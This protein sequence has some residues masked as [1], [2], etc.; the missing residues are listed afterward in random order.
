[1]D[2]AVR[3]TIQREVDAGFEDQVGFLQRLVRFPSTRGNEREVQAFMAGAMRDR[4]L[5]VD[6]W[7]IQ[8]QDLRGHPGFSPV[9]VSYENAWNVV[10]TYEPQKPSGRSLILNG[11]VDVVPEGPAGMWTDPPFDAAVRDG[12]LYGRGAGDM[13][14]GITANLF[15]FDALRR[16][17]V[18]PAGKIHFESV[19]EEESTGNG[20]LASF[21]R[22]YRADCMLVPEPS[23]ARLLRANCGVVWFRVEVRGRPVH[24][25]SAT[26]GANAIE[27]AYEMVRALKKLEAEWNGRRSAHPRFAALPHSINFNIGKIQGGDWASSVPAWCTMDVRAAYYPGVKPADAMAEIE[28]CIRAAAQENEFL[29]EQPPTVVV[30]GFH[31]E[32]F[33]LKPGSEAEIVLRE[34]HRAEFDADLEDYVAPAYVDARVHAL[35]GGVPALVYGPLCENAHG[36]DERVNLDSLRRATRAIALFVAEWCGIE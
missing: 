2:A 4:E 17:Q 14:A 21:L 33:E 7:Q 1:M 15:A 11:H 13:K 16:A 35:Y 29:R 27:A 5:G 32:G 23:R 26:Q 8:E 3:E 31:T 20:A 24:V 28:A 9:A 18:R 34:A 36:F 22:G 6:E 10:G 25:H 30:N 19:V 12:W